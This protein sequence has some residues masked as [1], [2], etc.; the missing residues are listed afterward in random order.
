MNH[1]YKPEPLPGNPLIELSK[2]V[3]AKG[4]RGKKRLP[5][6]GFA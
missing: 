2:S 1:G 4:Q 6:N 3:A 5:L